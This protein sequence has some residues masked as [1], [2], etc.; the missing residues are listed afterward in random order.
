MDGDI[1]NYS[2]LYV[3][4]NLRE[5]QGT[6]N[7]DSGGTLRGTVKVLNKLGACDEGL[8]GYD[9]QKYK[10]RPTDECYKD[11]EKRK[12]T[13]YQRL[14]GLPDMLKCL[15]DGYPFIFGFMV[16]PEFGGPE[17][18]KTG[19]LHLPKAGESCQGGH[20]VCAVGY[21][22]DTKTVLVRNSWGEAW[23][24]GGYYTMPLDYISNPALAQDFWTI[25][26]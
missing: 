21:D 22:M 20:A 11:G 19:V 6:L 5:E 7:E 25:R 8:W 15:A 17:I 3:Y 24:Q 1:E 10:I 9:I 4:Y 26:K 14:E 12:I 18:A 13:E 16:Y 2:R 23:G